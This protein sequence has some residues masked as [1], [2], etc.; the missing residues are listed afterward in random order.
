MNRNHSNWTGRTHRRLTD[1]FG[2]HTDSVLH[3][4]P[5]R[6]PDHTEAWVTGA[7][8]AVLVIIAA[9]VYFEVM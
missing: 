8:L 2:P 6:K 5:S 1:A 7:C 9:L 3:P 4:M